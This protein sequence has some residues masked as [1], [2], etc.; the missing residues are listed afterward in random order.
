MENLSGAM[1]VCEKLGISN[2]D[3]LLSM[4]DFTGAARRQELI[5]ESDK[6]LIYRDFAHAPSK[7]KATVQGFREFHPDKKLTAFLEIHTFSSLNRD[8]LPQYKNSLD[9][10]DEAY[11]YFDPEVVSHKKLPPLD[12]EFVKSCFGNDKV[13]IITNKKELQDRISEAGKDEGILL[14]MSSGNFGET[15]LVG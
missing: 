1:M 14:L 8:F 3:F 2:N 7:V 11:V 4:A 9:G 13:R 12:P 5:Y 6:L 10:C 15:K